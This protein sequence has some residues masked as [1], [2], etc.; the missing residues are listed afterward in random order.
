MASL[1]IAL[2]YLCFISLGLPD[3][4]LGSAWP[5][6]YPSFGVP[7]SYM[8]F[9]SMTISAGT[10]ISSL[11]SDRLSKKLG[12]GLLTALSILLTV[13]GLIG[14]SFVKAY[15]M[16]FLMAIPYGL[17]A[18]GVDAVLNNYVALHLKARH[19]SWLHCMWGIGAFISPNIMA[20][21]LAHQGWQEGYRIVFIIQAV[22][23]LLVFISL[24]L[25]KKVEAKEPIETST[26]DEKPSLGIVGVFRLKGALFIFIAFFCYCALEQATFQWSASYYVLVNGVDEELAASLASLAFLGITVGR[27]LNGFLTIRFKDHQLIRAGAI[28]IVIGV[29]MLACSKNVYLSAVSFFLLGFGCGPIYPSIVHSTPALFGKKN[30]QAMIGVQMAF[31]YTAN[32]SMPALFGVLADHIGINVLPYFLAVFLVLMVVFYEIALRMRQKEK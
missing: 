10:I 9:V 12:P 7:V 24:P 6:I 14:F 19:M 25:W 4:L 3:S 31:A 21:G 26:E 16:F 22:I 27:L 2:I 18:G 11:L 23:C 13:A 5:S 17:G 28:F 32:L 15:W 8:S 30:S 1:L 29:I 20:F